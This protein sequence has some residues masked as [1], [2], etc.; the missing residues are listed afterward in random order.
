MRVLVTGATGFLAS[1]V[2]P[3]LKRWGDEVVG[4]DVRP[5]ADGLGMEFVQADI[6]DPKLPEK[7]EGPIDCVIHLAA[8]AA[9]KECYADPVRAFNVNVQATHNVLQVALKHRAKKAVLASSAHVYGISPR[10][11]PTDECHPLWLF[12]EYTVTKI[13]A[14]QLWQLFWDN[15][16]IST[17]VLRLYNGFGPG[18]TPGYFIP[19]MIAKAQRDGRIAMKGART[20]KDFVYAT[21]VARAFVAATRTSYVGV[22]NVGSG[23]ETP[24]GDV[25]AYLARRLAVP[26]EALPYPATQ[27]SRMWADRRRAA[28]VLGWVPTVSLEAGL[29]AVINA[30]GAAEGRDAAAL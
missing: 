8:I 9:P 16:G 21:D 12:D 28:R 1:Y 30:H 22:I 11:M 5:G 25:A 18:Q 13:L 7:V 3:E 2:I 4:L 10:Y 29:E 6:T 27:D 19:D 14:E 15:F 17:T 23:V 20:T 24:L 26:F